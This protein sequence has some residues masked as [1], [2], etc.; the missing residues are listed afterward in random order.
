MG[1]IKLNSLFFR[2][3]FRVIGYNKDHYLYPFHPIDPASAP[4]CVANV[5]LT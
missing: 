3:N 1:V 5:S 2:N 4:I